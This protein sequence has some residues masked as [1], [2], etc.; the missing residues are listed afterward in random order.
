M[1]HKDLTKTFVTKLLVQNS[2]QC[3]SMPLLYLMMA[4]ELGTEAYLSYSPSHSYVMFK[5]NK[6]RW[7]NLELT[8]GKLITEAAILGSGFIRLRH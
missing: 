7:N 1:G 3:H 4:Q 5:D 2:G 6:S 8:N